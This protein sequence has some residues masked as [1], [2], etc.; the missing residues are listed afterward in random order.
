MWIFFGFMESWLQGILVLETVGIWIF[1]PPNFD[2]CFKKCRTGQISPISRFPIFPGNFFCWVPKIPG[3]ICRYFWYVSRA[4]HD[5]FF[6]KELLDPCIRWI[7][8]H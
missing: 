8:G 4:F 1:Q 5:F 2:L 6:Q 7:R 3:L